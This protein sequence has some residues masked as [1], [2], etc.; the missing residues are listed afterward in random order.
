[1]SDAIADATGVSVNFITPKG[2]ETEKMDAM[3]A[4][5]T[6]PDLVTVG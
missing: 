5:D 3:I 1:M 6:L 2:N 4:S